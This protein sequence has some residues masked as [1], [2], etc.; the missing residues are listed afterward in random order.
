MK[1][2]KHFVNISWAIF[3]QGFYSLAHMFLNFFA[4]RWLSTNEFG[5]LS[6][7]WAIARYIRSF[8]EAIIIEP[9]LVFGSSNLRAHLRDYLSKIMIYFFLLFLIAIIFAIFGIIVHIPTLIVVFVLSEVFVLLLIFLRK[10]GFVLYQIQYSTF[11]SI[12]YAFILILFLVLFSHKIKQDGAILLAIVGLS[13]MISNLMLLK[14]FHIIPSIKKS[15]VELKKIIILHWKYGRWSSLASLFTWF[16]RNIYYFVLPIFGSVELAGNM[17]ALINFLL[18]INLTLASL[19][20]YL[21]VYFS[22]LR[23]KRL[24]QIFVF[25]FFTIL[26]LT[27]FLGI[28]MG[29][30]HEALINIVYGNRYKNISNLLWIVAFIMIVNGIGNVGQ[31][32]LKALKR[33]NLVFWAQVLA[34]ISA[35]FFSFIFIPYKGLTGAFIAMLLSNIVSSLCIMFFALNIIIKGKYEKVF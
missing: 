27:V 28:F 33:P 3:D 6:I 10:C 23:G 35:I 31:M 4:A 24:F 15:E 9:I 11:A 1:I 2:K 7:L 30:F 13:S 34:S 14:K 8:H 32:L 12:L 22:Q 20:S 17:R 21:L 25:S 18:P 16:P 5:L 29:I 19:S 26:L